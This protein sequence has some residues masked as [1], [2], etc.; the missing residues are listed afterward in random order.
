[1]RII[2]PFAFVVVAASA[3][4]Q[5]PAPAVAA[6]V[7]AGK[8][9]TIIAGYRPGGGVDN[10]ARL[11]GAHIGRHIPGAPTII[12]KNMP[13][14]GGA[15]LANWLYNKADKD[16]L[17]I[18]VP[19]RSW[20]MSKLLK[21]PGVRFDP[22]KFDYIGSLGPVPYFLFVRADSGIRSL[23]DLKKS[24]RPVVFGGLTKRASNYVV[25]AILEADGW[26]VK[27][28]HGYKGT[29]NILLAIEQKEVE[30]MYASYSTIQNNRGDLIDNK[31]IV[32]IA[33]AGGGKSAAKLP[34]LPDHMSGKA[35]GVYKLVTAPSTWGV[36]V[37]APPGTDKAA[38]SILRAAYE[39]MVKDPVFLADAKKRGIEAEEPNTGSEVHAVIADV[40][41]SADEDSVKAYLA[42]VQRTEKK[43]KKK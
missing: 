6:D 34:P 4:V 35:R 38:L 8:Q 16:G 26:P 1:M 24:K 41:N 3:T 42:Y 15:R 10:N 30:G 17:T 2:T 43:K 32:P 13:G 14:A 22:L 33:S 5:A 36:P 18:A 28:L 37:V 39:K 31:V 19:G 21:D 9:L 11:V 29:A 7:F 12:N 27:A 25:P 23:D 40:L 20:M